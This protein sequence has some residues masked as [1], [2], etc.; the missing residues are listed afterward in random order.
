M[1]STY[2]LGFGK[3]KGNEDE[4]RSKRMS[5]A[6]RGDVAEVQRGTRCAKPYANTL[7]SQTNAR[8]YDVQ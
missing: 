6:M 5:C 8:R 4:C 3:M 2:V 7:A 1:K